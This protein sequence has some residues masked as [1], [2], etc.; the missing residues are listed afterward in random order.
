MTP[1]VL[2]LL[3]LILTLS[4]GAVGQTYTAGNFAGGIPRE[5][6]LTPAS[7][8][9]SPA[10]VALDSSGNVY[11]ASY[12]CIFKLD[13]SGGLTRIAG[14]YTAGTSGDGGPATAAQLSFGRYAGLAVDAAGNVYLP[15]TAIRKISTSGTISS[16]ATQGQLATPNHLAVDNSGNIYV[17]ETY[18]GKVDRISAA[19]V[20]TTY[21]GG[22]HASPLSGGP[23][24][25]VSLSA[26]T[27]LALDASGN[28][29][30]LDAGYSTVFKVSPS[31]A[32]T[33]VAG[34]GS[35]VRS[36]VD[37][38]DGGPA[39][40]AS[41]GYPS[42]LAVDAAGNLYIATAWF[43]VRKVSPDGIIK[44]VA[45]N[46]DWGYSGDGGAATGAS[47]SPSG[48]AVDSAGALYIADFGSNRIRKVSPG[49]TIATVAG[50]GAYGYFSGDGGPA[51]GAQ[52]SLPGP[53]A[54]DQAG[55]IFV[56]DIG[57]NRVRRISADGTITT[58]AGNGNPGYSGDGGPA[59]RAGIIP[60]GGLAVD[61]GGNLYIRDSHSLRKVSLDGTIATVP[62]TVPLSSG[63]PPLPGTVAPF[64]ITTS[65]LHGNGLAADGA[66]NI[67]T[68]GAPATGVDKIG[69]D[70]SISFVLS[71]HYYP[72]L[73]AADAAGNL[74][75]ESGYYARELFE[76]TGNTPDP[77]N[78]PL[79]PLANGCT[80]TVEETF[81]A[82]SAL[83]TD[84]AGNLYAAEDT[85]AGSPRMRKYTTA[86]TAY[87]IDLSNIV[88]PLQIFAMA[89]DASGNIYTTDARNNVIRVLKPTLATPVLA[90]VT[91]AASNLTG[92]VAPGE[93]V[94]LRGQGLGPAQLASCQYGASGLIDPILYGTQ[95]LF[96]GIPVPVLYASA[97][98]VAALV[99]YSVS[100]ASAQVSV[101]YQG[102]ISAAISVPVAPSAPALFTWDSSGHGQAAAV[103]QDGSVNGA[104]RPAKA[105]DFVSLYATGGGQTSPAGVDGKLPSSPLPLTI[106]PVTVT[107]GGQSV[108]PQYAG[109]A[110]GY[111]TGLMQVNAQ[112]P[113]NVSP[114][115]A[116]P[117]VIQVG[118]AISRAG[119]TIAVTGK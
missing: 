15:G 58:V 93:I 57:N 4:C 103:N 22:G 33:T 59:I 35:A 76:I 9:G 70:G 28:L 113:L 104:A 82:W 61:P 1:P 39:T 2:R 24:T 53:I 85:P 36:T 43:H 81:P 50:N 16:I 100:G 30:F 109:G 25:G 65:I 66:G 40:S 3:V 38:G 20:V 48:V 95:V 8:I 67:F 106:L 37:S 80:T 102:A 54:M 12:N 55:N 105:G 97:S 19:G 44:T 31:G 11:F 14:D 111:I 78:H 6:V 42:E 118:E 29:Y 47:V 49:G 96:N 79:P 110:P 73:I 92:P 115:S 63:S 41:L 108:K 90:A 86:G 21:A 13:P 52:L 7:P 74:F 117:V 46:G 77:F 72:G 62:G 23:A 27:G 32:L 56:A 45:G 94:V 112:I 91:S 83:A 87:P 88:P 17:A 68:E 99:P 101:A 114:G 34:N 98:Q 26:P 60:S 107:I 84:R 69:P 116:V 119:V 10:G 51:A 75:W 18:F 89:V 5:T 71:D 64:A